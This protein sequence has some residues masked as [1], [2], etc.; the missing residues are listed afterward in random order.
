MWEAK[1]KKKTWNFGTRKF[2][3]ARKSAEKRNSHTPVIP[4][5][6]KVNLLWFWK[7]TFLYYDCQQTRVFFMLFKGWGFMNS[8][9]HFSPPPILPLMHIFIHEG[10][11]NYIWRTFHPLIIRQKLKENPAT[12]VMNLFKITGMYLKWLSVI[13]HSKLFSKPPDFVAY[14]ERTSL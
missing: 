8:D 1:D 3:K 9:T 5:V 7:R 4:I 11:K 10:V 14:S 12:N 6:P 2:S 13:V